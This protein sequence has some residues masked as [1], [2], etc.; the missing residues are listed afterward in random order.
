MSLLWGTEVPG[1]ARVP[2][3]SA[4]GWV[5]LPERRWKGTL[6]SNAEIV[7]LTILR[8]GK[9]LDWAKSSS[10]SSST[11]IR[12]GIGQ[13]DLVGLD[14]Q[15]WLS[16]GSGGTG[17]RTTVPSATYV[18]DILD[19]QVIETGRLVAFTR[20]AG[21]PPIDL[22]LL[23]LARIDVKFRR[24]RLWHIRKELASELDD[25]LARILTYGRSGTVET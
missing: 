9:T 22:G 19:N 11:S 2:V 8:C 5:P 24:N 17:I 7:A 25:T 21:S 4:G 13:Y 14:V 16:V 20:V 23:L 1:A 3:T 12:M 6:T 15:A 18:P 10:S